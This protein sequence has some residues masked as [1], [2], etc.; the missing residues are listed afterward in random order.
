MAPTKNKGGRPKGKTQRDRA[1]IAQMLKEYHEGLRHGVLVYDANGAV[2]NGPDG[3]P[4]RRRPSAAWLQSCRQF[5]KDMGCL[6]RVKSDPSFVTPAKGHSGNLRSVVDQ[7]RAEGRLRREDLPDAP[8]GVPERG[9]K[10]PPVDTEGADPG[11][12]RYP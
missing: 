10:L 3:R 2:V 1:V 8:R 12:W 9:G 5:L 7:L 4:L 11:E 6:D